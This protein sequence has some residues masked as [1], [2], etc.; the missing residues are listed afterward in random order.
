[1]TSDTCDHRDAVLARADDALV[2]GHRLSEWCGHAPMP[3]EDLALANIGLDLIGQA[4][5]LYEHAATLDAAGR[6]ADDFAFQRD[7]AAFR[8]LALV[9][10]P[11]GDFAATMVRLLVYAG[12]ARAMWAELTGSTDA[13]LAAIA[14]RSV[15]EVAYHW[16]HAAEWVIRLGDGTAESHRRAQAALD[17]VWR[18]TDEMFT[19]PAGEIGLIEAGVVVDPARVRAAWRGALDAVFDQATL[20][21]PMAVRGGAARGGQPSAHRRELLATMQSVARAH[22]GAAW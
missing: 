2:L 22:P 18:F 17:E 9:E 15:P 6:S 4:T 16:R 11:N 20:L 3:E 1:M 13:A 5:A 12:F 7:A 14:A 8:N 19:V 21:P 10:Q